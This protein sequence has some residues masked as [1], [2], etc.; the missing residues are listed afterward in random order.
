MAGFPSAP[1]APTIIRQGSKLVVP[2]L[3]QPVILPP[4]CV[5]CG[6]AAD[7]KTVEKT[8]YW[9]HPALYILLVSPIIYVIVAVIVRKS[10]K[11]NVPLC[12]HHAQRRG[13]AVM[14]AWLLPLIGIADIFILPRFNV[15]PGIVALVTIAFIVAGLVIW[16]VAGNIMRP[17]SID[18]YFAEFSGCCEIF[19]QQFPQATPQAATPVQPYMPPPPPAR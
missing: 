14:L 5:R 11:V 13:T 7:G 10:V 17:T 16:A 1:A 4:L 8:F 12:A 15:D 2:V 19:L 6:A 18:K 3:N 9:H